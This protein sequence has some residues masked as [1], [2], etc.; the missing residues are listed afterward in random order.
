MLAIDRQN[1]IV[2]EFSVFKTWEERY[3]HLIQIGK[4][5]PPFPEEKRLE[6]LKVKGCQSQ[7]WLWANLDSEGRV[8]LQADSDALI[9]KGL[10]ALLLKLYSHLTPDEILSTEPTFISEIGLSSNLSP[11]RA[12]GLVSMI[13]QIKYYATAFK[14]LQS[15]G[16]S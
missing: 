6:D 8:V 3:Q 2:A 16:R 5:L 1:K 11:S 15:Y 14:H 13:K 10:V 7:V 9:V 4:E 12:N